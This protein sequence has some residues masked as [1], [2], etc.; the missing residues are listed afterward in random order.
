MTEKKTKQNVIEIED[1]GA[2]TQII[3]NS[4]MGCECINENGVKTWHSSPTY[5]KIDKAGVKKLWTKA[6]GKKA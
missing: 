1:L 6:T 4:L 5:G 2:L 3:S